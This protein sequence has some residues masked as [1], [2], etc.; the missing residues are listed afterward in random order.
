MKVF[1]FVGGGHAYEALRPRLSGAGA[2]FVCSSMAEIVE[3]IMPQSL[4]PPGE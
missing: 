1:G 2:D 4:S 3:L